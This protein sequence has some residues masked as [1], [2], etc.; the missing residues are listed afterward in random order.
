[1][2]GNKRA[3]VVIYNS[4]ASNRH[5]QRISLAWKPFYSNTFPIFGIE[6]FERFPYNESSFIEECHLLCSKTLDVGAPLERH[7]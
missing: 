2:V 7:A 4:V 5:R 6:P 3:L 1:M